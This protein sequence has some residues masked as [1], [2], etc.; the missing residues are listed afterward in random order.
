MGINIGKYNQTHN[1]LLQC[2]KVC[3]KYIF[4]PSN[5]KLSQN[6][7]I[8]ISIIHNFYDLLFIYYIHHII[9]KC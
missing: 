8:I 3:I 1:M 4:L 6:K 2:I 9:R 5:V 7:T